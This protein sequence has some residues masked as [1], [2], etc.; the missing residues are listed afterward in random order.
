MTNLK[1]ISPRSIASLALAATVL[2]AAGCNS[3]SK[4]APDVA[5]KSNPAS[6]ASTSITPSPGE[7][8]EKHPWT[9]EQILTCTVSQCWQISGK[10]ED[11]F[12]DI[13]QDLAVISAQNRNLTLPEDEKAG[14]KAGEYIKAKAKEDHDSLLYAIVDQAV[15]QVGTEAT[16][17]TK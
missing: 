17:A 5:P 4:P 3:E 13:V 10:S 1:F 12:F 2:A 7:A 11:S 9:T 8:S 15:R 16:A 14:Q 6:P